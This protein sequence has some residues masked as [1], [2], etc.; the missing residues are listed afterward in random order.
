[1]TAIAS[2]ADAASES[3]TSLLPFSPTRRAGDW[4]AISGQIG[5]RDGDLVAGGAKA[6]TTQAMQNLSAVLA[7]AGGSLGSIVKV[8]V[9]LNSMA[10]YEEMNVAYAAAFDGL[11]LPARTAVA[12]LGLPRQASVEIE[13]WAYLPKDEATQ[14]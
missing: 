9:Y 2:D 6:E 13:A 10:H 8:N 12:V 11:P 7:Q 3:G 1:M 4:V 14:S 5:S